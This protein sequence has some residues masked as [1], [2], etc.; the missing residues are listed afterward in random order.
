MVAA[1]G[2]NSAKRYVKTGSFGRL[3][4]RSIAP[5]SEVPERYYLRRR[6]VWCA[7]ALALL[8]PGLWALLG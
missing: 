4:G 3:N 7:I 8:L 6:I 2:H 1:R 5:G